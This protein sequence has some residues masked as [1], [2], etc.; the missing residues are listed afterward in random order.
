MANFCPNGTRPKLQSCSLNWVLLRK[1]KWKLHTLPVL[2][3]SYLALRVETELTSGP[4]LNEGDETATKFFSMTKDGFF[5]PATRE[6]TSG[7]WSST[8]P[9]AVA[10]SWRAVVEVESSKFRWCW[11]DSSEDDEFG[12]ELLTWEL[13]WVVMWRANAAALP[14]RRLHTLHSNLEIL[15]MK[16]IARFFLKGQQRRKQKLNC[17]AQCR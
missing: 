2:R 15:K 17:H 11:S 5:T 16:I 12:V 10:M 1:R 13:T 7:W 3:L 9:L 6:A 8:M 14:T 4:L